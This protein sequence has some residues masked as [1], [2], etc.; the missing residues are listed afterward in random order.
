[1]SESHPKNP[2]TIEEIV[3]PS[4]ESAD[5]AT[6][7][8]DGSLFATDSVALIS[9]KLH[10]AESFLKLIPRDCKFSE[11]VRDALLIVME[12]IKSEAGSII[13]VDHRAQNLFFR[14]I[15]GAS[16]DQ[17]AKFVIPMGKGIVGH[18]AESRQPMIVEDVE[19][20]QQH[21]RAVGNAVGFEARNLVAFP[22]LVRGHVYG[23]LELLNRVGEAKFSNQDIELLNFYCAMFSRAIEARMMIAWSKRERDDGAEVV[24]LETPDSGKK[25]A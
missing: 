17:L 14:A 19:G 8:Q 16:G 10:I 15:V 21:L 25:A 18:V 13:E 23:V 6:A 24:T 12:V 3:L 5:P 7:L 20:N 4:L 22:I 9:G 11:Y 2:E 1:M